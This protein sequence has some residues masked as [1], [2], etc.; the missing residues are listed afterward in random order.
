MIKIAIL[1]YGESGKILYRQN[2]PFEYIKRTHPEFNI[3]F[4][5]NVNQ[6]DQFAT[7]IVNEFDVIVLSG[8]NSNTPRAF[9]TILKAARDRGKISIYDVDD[10]DWEIPKENPVQSTFKEL[11]VPEQVI[12][13]MKSALIVT[14]PSRYLANLISEFNKNVKIF[15][16]ALDYEYY[17]WNLPKAEDEWI[18]I[19]WAGGSSHLFDLKLIEGLGTWILETFPNTKFLLGGYDTRIASTKQGNM[20]LLSWADDERCIWE[21]YKKVLFKNNVDWDRVEIVPTRKIDIYPIVFKNADILLA[22]LINNKFNLSKSNLKLLEASARHIPIITSDI[23]TYSEIITHSINGYLASNINDWKKY[24]TRLIKD[25][26]L[27]IRIGNKLYEDMK[28]EHN[29]KFQAEKRI[30]L[31]KNVYKQLY[32]K[33]KEFEFRFGRYVK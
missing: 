4:F 7:A 27:R 19:A 25:K 33:R 10:L 13:C 15:P 3:Q 26:E 18:R 17:Y 5:R 20:N 14:T 21:H 6:T 28:K 31:I 11:K 32:K 8:H 2:L 24:L 16:N 9:F 1:T 12:E 22:P 23:K 29:I 30:E